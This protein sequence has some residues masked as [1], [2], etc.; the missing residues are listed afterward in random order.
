[1]K[2][3]EF[4]PHDGSPPLSATGSSPML[5]LPDAETQVVLCQHGTTGVPPGTLSRAAILPGAFNP[6]HDGHRQLREAA[7]CFL[8]QPVC[9]ELSLENVDKPPLERCDV[10][11]RLATMAEIPVF[12]TRAPHFTQK[13]RLFPRSW[14]VVGFDTAERLLDLRYYN[15]EVRRRHAALSQ[16]LSGGIRFLVAG[17]LTGPGDRSTFSVRSQL[18]VPNG[19]EY[20][21]TELPEERFRVDMWSSEIRNR[22]GDNG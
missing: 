2:G 13:A 5:T 11:R 16:L 3:P 8:G 12:L 7:A 21:F 18:Q 14:F 15:N 4:G 1:M 22:R 17:R 19:F 9:F 10:Q 20:L 6:V